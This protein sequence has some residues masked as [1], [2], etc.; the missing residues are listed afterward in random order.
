[1]GS[2]AALGSLLTPGW[3]LSLG[4]LVD[5]ASL[6]SL[7]WVL[8]DRVPPPIPSQALVLSLSEE[9]S[10]GTTMSLPFPQL[11]RAQCLCPTMGVGWEIPAGFCHL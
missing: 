6:L 7:G 8:E 10:H 4:W 5:L 11:Q 1:M 3:L 9:A 2:L